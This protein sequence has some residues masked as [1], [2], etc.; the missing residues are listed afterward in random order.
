M[1]PARCAWAVASLLIALP[2]TAG[3]FRCGSGLVRDG[4][5]ASDV[6][7][8]CGEPTQVSSRLLLRPPM[9]WR[10][11]RQIRAAGGDI[12]VRVET[13]LYNFGPDR[14]MQQLEVEDGRVTKLETLGY[15]HR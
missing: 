7:A 3:S 10:Y 11:G 4:D 14:L 12:E 15:G 5:A 9:V 2:C 1:H 8:K 6:I 13:W